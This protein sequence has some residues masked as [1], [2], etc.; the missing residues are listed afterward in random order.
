MN[1]LVSLVQ[2]G[3]LTPAAYLEQL[4]NFLK[5]TKRLALTFKKANKTDEAQKAMIRIKLITREISEISID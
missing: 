5:E 2:M 1:L 4:N 3:S